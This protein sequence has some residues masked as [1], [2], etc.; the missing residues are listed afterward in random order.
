VIV[1]GGNQGNRVSDS[2]YPVHRVLAY[3][4]A[5]AQDQVGNRP[6]LKDGSVGAFVKALQERLHEL[7]YHPGRAD[8]SF[9]D[10]TDAAVRAFQKAYS[11]KVDGIVGEMTWDALDRAVPRPERDVTVQ[12]L[13]E[14]RSRTIGLT[15]LLKKLGWGGG[16][17][18]VG[19]VPLAENLSAVPS[20]LAT[21]EG[22]IQAAQAFAVEYWH[23]IL[24]L[25][26][27]GA[28]WYVA[29]RLEQVRLDDA[30]TGANPT[31]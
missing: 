25:I 28:I 19:S 9:D 31:K 4:R 2:P 26:G 14:D 17:V 23:V 18:G 5:V 3:R 13:R 27:V 10:R 8:G 16:I 21:A 15:D 1:R 24:I 7:R 22:A 12:D 30:K 6:I 11:L 20:Q 29:N